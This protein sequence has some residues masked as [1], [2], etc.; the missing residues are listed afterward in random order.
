MAA[1]TQY[2]ILLELVSKELTCDRAIVLT[3]VYQNGNALVYASDELK[4]DLEIVLAAVNQN[5]LLLKH[6]SDE[7]KN[8][9]EIVLTA[10][11][12]NGRA[13]EFASF[14][15]RNDNI[16]L[17]NVLANGYLVSYDETFIDFACDLVLHFERCYMGVFLMGWYSTSNHRGNRQQL[18][19]SCSDGVDINHV[20]IINSKLLL[21]N[22]L[23]K[24]GSIQV[25][26][27]IADY[28]GVYYGKRLL[29][30]RKALQRIHS[31]Q[32]RTKEEKRPK[33]KPKTMPKVSANPIKPIPKALCTVC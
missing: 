28:A 7:L 26:K 10:V 23:G 13:A 3:A 24:Y 18:K 1:V 29:T 17:M 2:G 20:H 27:L 9:R 21:L 5:G 19:S 16:V 25:K 8:D 32:P 14:E 6:A 11:K 15:M 31:F 30:A 33:S 22:K 4:S 12:Q